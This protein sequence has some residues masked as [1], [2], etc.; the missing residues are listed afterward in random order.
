MATTAPARRDSV[1]RRECQTA[2]VP[3]AAELGRVLTLRLPRAPSRA[4]RT[5]RM[6][7]LLVERAWHECEV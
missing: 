5:P 4:R 2:R 6:P 7:V 1:A 3:R